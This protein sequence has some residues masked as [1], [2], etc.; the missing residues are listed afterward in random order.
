MPNQ[1]LQWM[2]YTA[3]LFLRHSLRSFYGAKICYAPVTTELGV[4]AH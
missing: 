3:Q 4:R 2:P 1:A